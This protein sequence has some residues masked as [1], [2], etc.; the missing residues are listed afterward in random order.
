MTLFALVWAF[1]ISVRLFVPVDQKGIDVH[2][3]LEIMERP[4]VEYIGEECE[5]KLLH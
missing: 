4:S 2:P 3:A 1:D 5:V